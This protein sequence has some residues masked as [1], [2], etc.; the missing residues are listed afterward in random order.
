MGPKDGQLSGMYANM[1][2]KMSLMDAHCTMGHV[3]LG[4]V[5]HAIRTGV[6]T[7]IELT[8]NKEELCEACAQAKPT[9]KPFPI[10]AKNCVEEYGEHIHANLWGP[11]A[12]KNLGGALYSADFTDDAM[13]FTHI[14]FLKLKKDILAMY[15]KLDAQIQTQTHKVIKYL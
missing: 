9:C 14:E 5:K 8:N 6:T 4:A 15:Q 11:A 2:A 3:S 1:A 10:V 13:R 12:V 7:G